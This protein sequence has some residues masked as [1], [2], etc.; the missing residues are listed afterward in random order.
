MKKQIKEV[1]AKILYHRQLGKNY[2]ILRLFAPEIA[3]WAQPGQFVMLRVAEGRDPFLRRPFSLA[4]IFPPGIEG[5]NKQKEGQVEIWYQVKGRGTYLMSKFRVGERIDILGPLGQ[6]FWLEENFKK[7]IL[8]GGGIGLAPLIAW[9]EKIQGEKKKRKLAAEDLRV[10]FFLGGKS[11]EEILGWRELKELKIEPQIITEDGSWGKS[12]L[13]T[14][15]LESE[16]MTG[17]NEC[18]GIYACGPEAMLAKVAQIAEQFDLPCQVLLE[19]RLACGIGACLGCAVKVRLERG[20]TEV[21]PESPAHSREREEL[22]GPEPSLE[23]DA[24]LPYRYARVCQEG[25]VFTAANIIWE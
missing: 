25:P 23:V 18:T 19:S 3:R 15:L 10:L 16:L 22:V 4:R 8:V 9:A 24:P 11:R 20:R 7:V 12:G 6:G 13:V 17:Q 1:K 2:Y 21:V 14:D 5:K